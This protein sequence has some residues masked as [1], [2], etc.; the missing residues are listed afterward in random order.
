MVVCSELIVFEERVTVEIAE[1][2]EIKETKRR[3][4]SFIERKITVTRVTS[5][6]FKRKLVVKVE[7]WSPEIKWDCLA[8]EENK[9]RTDSDFNKTKRIRK[10]ETEDDRQPNT[11]E[12][13][14]QIKILLLKETT[15]NST[16]VYWTKSNCKII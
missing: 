15:Q 13:K 14:D 7:N 9:G 11:A 2:I 6:K 4:R 12:R 8:L 5:K 1:W 10:Q 3:N 16:K